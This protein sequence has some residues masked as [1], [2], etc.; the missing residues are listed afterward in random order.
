M[1][2]PD[3][4]F[5]SLAEITMIKPNKSIRMRGDCTIPSAMVINMTITFEEEAGV[6]T[7]KV[8]HRMSG[9]FDDDLPAGFE[10]GWLDGLQKLKALVEA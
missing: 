8:D 5:N 9:E 10:E 2:L 3:G 6:T 4:G 1:E 7:V